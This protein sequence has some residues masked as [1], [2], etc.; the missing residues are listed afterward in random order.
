SKT[1]VAVVRVPLHLLRLVAARLRRLLDGLRRVLRQFLQILVGLNLH[2]E[3][4]AAFEIEAEV[5]VFGERLLETVGREVA[6]MRPVARADDG[7][8]TDNRDDGD[9]DDALR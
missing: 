8:E 3:V 5:Y 2:D 7:V 1:I 9:D 6:Q 4:R